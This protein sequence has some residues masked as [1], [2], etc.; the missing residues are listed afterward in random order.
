MTLT[1]FVC[2]GF[3]LGM[4]AKIRIGPVSVLPRSGVLTAHAYI[5]VPSAEN[6]ELSKGLSFKSDVGQIIYSLACFARC[7][8]FCLLLFKVH[9]TSFSNPLS[10]FLPA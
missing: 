8:E 4:Q 6:P 5:T 3:S 2:A 10:P 1:G 9:S 7:H